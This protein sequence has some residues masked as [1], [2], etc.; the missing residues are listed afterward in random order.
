MGTCLTNTDGSLTPFVAKYC[1]ALGY[2]MDMMRTMSGQEMI[3]AMSEKLN[4]VVCFCNCLKDSINGLIEQ[5]EEVSVLS[6]GG[7]IVGEFEKMPGVLAVP[8]ITGNL[9]LSETSIKLGGSFS[10]ENSIL[11]TEVL[12][13]G[14][15]AE[16]FAN[17][18][19]R[20]TDVDGAPSITVSAQSGSGTF[21]I[22]PQL[23]PIKE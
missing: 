16:A 17:Y 14:E 2:D 13:D 21:R 6:D 5:Y 20:C 3:C 10:F 15:P 12:T 1:T 9:P 4:E 22:P 7:L 8:E 18:G 11:M 19:V 23:V